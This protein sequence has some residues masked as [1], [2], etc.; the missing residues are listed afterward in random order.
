MEEERPPLFKIL[1][2]YR[3]AKPFVSHFNL[4]IA[5]YTSWLWLLKFYGS[6]L[7]SSLFYIIY[8]IIRCILN[9]L[10]LKLENRAQKNPNVSLLVISIHINIIISE[11]LNKICYDSNCRSVFSL[12]SESS[13]SR[14]HMDISATAELFGKLSSGQP[15]FLFTLTDNKSRIS[16]NLVSLFDYFTVQYNNSTRIIFIC[17]TRIKT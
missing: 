1:I 9:W 16:V 17:F 5:F 13:T 14:V 11:L 2:F 8:N 3:I 10:L 15:V 6:A 4:K 7:Y 12:Y